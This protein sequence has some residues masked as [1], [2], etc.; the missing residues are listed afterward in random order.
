M[1]ARYFF[2]AFELDEARF[3]LCF[4]GTAVAV[5]P[6][7]LKM[8]LH[9]VAHR[10]RTVGA[11]ELFRVLW[12][13]ERV[14][15]ASIKRAVIGARRAL[16]E[17][18]DSQASVRTV[19]GFGYQ[20]SAEVRVAASVGVPLAVVE[21]APLSAQPE[22]AAAPNDRLARPL[23]ALSAEGRRLIEAAS[24]LGSEFS[25]A[26]LAE[27]ASRS[28]EQVFPS[29]CAAVT[30]QLLGQVK[31]AAGRYYF[32]LESV[33]DTLYEAVAP[34]ERARL[35]GQAA[36]A[37]DARGPGLGDAHLLAIAE[38]YFRA[39]P[40]HDHGRALA[41][42]LR[43]ARSERPQ[44][45][46]AHV[47]TLL[48]RAL[49][50]LE[51]LEPSRVERMQLLL[52]LGAAQR[53]A[54]NLTDARQSLLAAAEIAQVLGRIDILTRVAELLGAPIEAGHVDLVQVR[55]LRE[56][57]AGLTDG[58]VRAPLLDALLAGALC[59]A[60]DPDERARLALRAYAATPALPPID[61]AAVLERCHEALSEPGHRPLRLAVSEELS[62][63]A[64]RLNDPILVMR[65]C[66]FQIRDALE[67][68]E[69]ESFDAAL[70]TLELTSERAQEPTF[71]WY[72]R[73][74]RCVRAY[75]AG[76]LAQAERHADEALAL[77]ATAADAEHIHAA[78]VIGTWLL[79]GKLAESEAL[80]REMSARYPR[81]SG[82]RAML[83]SLQLQTGRPALARRALHQLLDEDLQALRGDPFVLSALSPCA[84]LCAQ[85][86]D[87][88]AAR[89]LYDAILP[90]AQLHSTVHL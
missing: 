37:L 86:G 39:A 15:V 84:D 40:T 30:A 20:F 12:P 87:E 24:V 4:H 77:H 55:L 6:K 33:R 72:G 19:R 83:G 29:V 11:D 74:Y 62:R 9:L 54:N 34:S 17:S 48:A 47:A 3:E 43:L 88:T 21:S 67:H 38:H 69:L 70:A 42:N 1:A 56:A 51:L 52:E 10:D 81:L 41:Y 49:Q 16:G 58:D 60:G 5:Q 90:H 73:A 28:I 36:R 80:M 18:G 22:S 13:E 75:I 53:R 66:T 32:V 27:V 78:Q 25:I 31:G 35:H 82:W 79:Q 45:D 63:L 46:P 57:R 85:V 71:R 50:L 64:Q 44:M 2:G 89:W 26:L 59:Y 61:R 23:S 7:V 76:D 14:G 8:L 68:G 65:G